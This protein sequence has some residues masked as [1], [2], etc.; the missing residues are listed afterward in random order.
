MLWLFQGCY[1]LHGY[2]LFPTANCLWYGTFTVREGRGIISH[3]VFS[4]CECAICCLIRL[5]T[6][7]FWLNCLDHVYLLL[8]WLHTCHYSLY[9]YIL[10]YLHMVPCQIPGS[11]PCLVL[12]SRP[13]SRGGLRVG[14]GWPS[15][16]AEGWRACTGRLSAVICLGFWEYFCSETLVN[17]QICIN[18]LINILW[19]LY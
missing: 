14:T 10:C 2:Y 16:R 15:G 19:D 3:G 6:L 12:R 8:I 1:P 17:W 11:N 7:S 9:V 5:D 13:W 4:L 18:I